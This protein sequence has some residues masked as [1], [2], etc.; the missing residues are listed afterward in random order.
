MHRFWMEKLIVR[1]IGSLKKRM[2]T[3]AKLDF[4]IH[5]IPNI[6]GSTTQ[7]IVFLVLLRETFIHILNKMIL[8]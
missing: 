3:G 6:R 2:S 8:K 4:A 5:T 7:K 1:F